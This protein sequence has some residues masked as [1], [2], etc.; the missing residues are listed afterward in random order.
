MVKIKYTK[1]KGRGVFAKQNIESGTIVFRNHYIAEA[2]E[3]VQNTIFDCYVYD[4]GDGNQVVMALGEGS[5]IN[6]HQDPNC[7]FYFDGGLLVFKAIRD[8]GIGEELTI[9]YSW[10]EYPWERK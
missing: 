7:D 3:K 6:H 1:D 8:I 9:D 2:I 5:L 10:K 4:Y